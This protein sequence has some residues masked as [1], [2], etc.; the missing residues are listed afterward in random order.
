MKL[1]YIKKNKKFFYPII[2]FIIV[3]SCFFLFYKGST[4]IRSYLITENHVS[5]NNKKI[6]TEL[7][8]L[9]KSYSTE[10]EEGVSVYDVMKSVEDHSFSFKATN[11]PGLGYFIEEINGIKGSPGKYWFYYVNGKEANVGVSKY[12]I[13]SG[14]IISWEQK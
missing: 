13:K 3:F 1:S 12:F 14:D 10:T 6:I 7:N 5:E 8:I 11:Y 9:G 4:I 2:L